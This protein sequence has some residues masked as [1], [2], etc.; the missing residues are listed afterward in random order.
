MAELWQPKELEKKYKGKE[1]YDL[2]YDV[3]ENKELSY[4]KRNNDPLNILYYDWPNP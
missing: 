3:S 1:I 2:L 4:Y